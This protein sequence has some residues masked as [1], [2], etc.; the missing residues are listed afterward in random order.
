MHRDHPDELHA[1]DTQSHRQRAAVRPDNSAPSLGCPHALRDFDGH[2][3]AHRRDDE[4]EDDEAEAVG[5]FDHADSIDR[6][7]EGLLSMAA[8]VERPS[9][10]TAAESQDASPA[11]LP[12]IELARVSCLLPL[13]LGPLA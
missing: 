9:A 1:P 2:I 8:D 11:M 5:L 6:G 12:D 13:P 4:G 10:M 7:K 3:T